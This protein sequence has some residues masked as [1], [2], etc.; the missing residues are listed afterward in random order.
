MSDRFGGNGA[1]DRLAPLQ[2]FQA[3]TPGASDLSFVPRAVLAGAA[4]TIDVVDY[5]GN[6]VAGV[7]VVQGMNP[8]RVRRITAATATGLVIAD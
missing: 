5:D 1:G 8:Y 7:P 3:I 2:R 4:G 6:T